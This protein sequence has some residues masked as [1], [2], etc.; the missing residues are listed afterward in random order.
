MNPSDIV[1]LVNVG[2]EKLLQESGG[3]DGDVFFLRLLFLIPSCEHHLVQQQLSTC[4]Q[5]EKPSRKRE[6]IFNWKR[7]R[8]SRR[9]RE[10]NACIIIL[11]F[12]SIDD[13]ALAEIEVNA[14]K[15]SIKYI[16]TLVDRTE[17]RDEAL[18]A[19]LNVADRIIAVVDNIAEVSVVGTVEFLIFTST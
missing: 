6:R 18:G 14:A 16:E 3:N 11:R 2:A 10:E 9:T 19:F 17:R 13:Q 7:N 4:P 12:E 1:C 5:E 15:L 8:E